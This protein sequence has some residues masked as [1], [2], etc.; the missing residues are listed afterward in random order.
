M[1][2]PVKHPIYYLFTLSLISLNPSHNYLSLLVLVANL[3]CLPRSI[4]W[5]FFINL[6][7]FQ[8][9]R[10]L[11]V[12][13]LFFYISH[14]LALYFF[15]VISTFVKRRS[16]IPLIKNVICT[17]LERSTICRINFCYYPQM[18]IAV[19]TSLSSSKI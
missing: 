15:H 18:L 10:P 12:L 17:L 8:W 1:L 19:T 7:C 3:G 16:I 6:G 9:V 5:M 11:L 13:D 2:Q 14:C 4:W